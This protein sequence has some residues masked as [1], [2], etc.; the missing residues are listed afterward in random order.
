MR[1]GSAHFNILNRDLIDFLHHW[2]AS[3]MREFADL[4]LLMAA[5]LGR[6]GVRFCLIQVDGDALASLSIEEQQGA[7]VPRL[8][9]LIWHDRLTEDLDPL[10]CL[11]SARRTE[12]S[13][14][15]CLH[16]ALPF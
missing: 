9:P 16:T 3:Q 6:L 11:V 8:L 4:L 12:G 1:C 14:Y 10:C 2:S 15:S 13:C 5:L 7:F